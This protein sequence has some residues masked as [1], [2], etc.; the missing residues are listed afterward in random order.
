MNELLFA[1]RFDD[2]VTVTFVCD[3]LITLSNGYTIAFFH[4]QDC[5]EHV[6]ADTQNVKVGMVLA[7]IEIKLVEGMGVLFNK[8]L[9]NC[10]NEQNGYYS[11]DLSLSILDGNRDKVFDYDN[12]PVQDE[13]Y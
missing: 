3:D 10:Y 9:I 8:V 2:L 6:W 4:D 5:C 1:C 12:V 13:I 7:N 11:S